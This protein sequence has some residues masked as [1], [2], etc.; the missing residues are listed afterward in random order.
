MRIERLGMSM[1]LIDTPDGTRFL[2]DPWLGTVGGNPTLVKSRVTSELLASVD[3]LLVSHGHTDHSEG[4]PS[5]VEINPEIEII[6]SFELGN[7]LLRKGYEHV[8]YINMGGSTTF[9]STVIHLMPASHES[10]YRSIDPAGDRRE[11]TSEYAGLGAGFLI[12]L[13]SGFRVYYAGDTG[14]CADMGLIGDYWRPDLAIVPVGGG[15]NSM[16]PEEAAYAVGKLLRVPHAIPCHWA[17]IPAEA[18]DPELMAKFVERARSFAGL[19]GPRGQQ[20][21]DVVLEHYPDIAV[22]VLE[23]GDVAELNVSHGRGGYFGAS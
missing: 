21:A 8:R 4:I 22:T 9:D 7:L 11:G 19:T 12:T 6:A 3:A 18:P 15:T 14:L 10:A 5:I 23:L 20:F 1:F 13:A 2:T 16:G 17:P